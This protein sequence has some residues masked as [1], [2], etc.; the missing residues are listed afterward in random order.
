MDGLEFGYH[1]KYGFALFA[2]R[3]FQKGEILLSE[4]PLIVS[5]T[6]TSKRD[7]A[8][9]YT[10]DIDLDVFSTF[11]AFFDSSIEIQ[12]IILNNFYL[13]STPELMDTADVNRDT[14]KRVFLVF[15]F[16]SHA[17]GSDNSPA[18][19]AIGSKMN[20]SCEAN[21]FYQSIDN[22][23]E[24]EQWGAAVKAYDEQDFD[25]ALDTFEYLRGNMLIDYEQ[26]GLKFRLYSCEVL[27]NRGLCYLYLGQTDQGLGD[28]SFAVKEKQT[29]EH[30][31]I[32][33]AIEVQ[34]K[35]KNVKTKDYLGKAKLVAA[36]DPED[37]FTGFTG[38]QQ[39]KKAQMS[40]TS[41][42][43]TGKTDGAV[44]D[45]PRP[46]SPPPEKVVIRPK[47]LSTNPKSPPFPIRATRDPSSRRRQNESAENKS[48]VRSGASTPLL[49]TNGNSELDAPISR[50][51]SL[52]KPSPNRLQLQN[53]PQ[54]SN[55]IDGGRPSP[56]LP[57]V[58][59]RVNSARE[60]NRPPMQRSSSLRDP[61]GNSNLRDPLSRSNSLRA[62]SPRGGVRTPQRL[63]TVNRQQYLQQQMKNMTVT[64]GYNDYNQD[65]GQYDN[66]DYN[67][68]SLNE[69]RRTPSL[70]G[71]GVNTPLKGSSFRSPLGLQGGLA[72][73]P[74]PEDGDYDY[75]NIVDD[76]YIYGD[77]DEPQFEM[78][79]PPQ[80]NFQQSSESLKIVSKIRVKCYYK[81]KTPRAIMVSTDIAYE[82]LSKRIQEKFSL[83]NPLKMKYKDE[84]GTMVMMGDQEDLDMAI[85]IIPM[86]ATDVGKMEVW[87]FV[88]L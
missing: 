65:P 44:L 24:L 18:I 42:L 29:E 69:Q 64:D 54:R 9:V 32:D 47:S 87:L 70:R 19:F 88:I 71:R 6:L 14:F 79:S 72:T 51:V 33:E 86:S 2:T 39:Q 30:D 49:D 27:F 74:T 60:S 41:P 73:P 82:D 52:R 78:I 81:D 17:F 63:N 61:V 62:V 85:S 26:L 3:D 1:P 38:A 23:Y 15:T 66:E 11:K 76:G 20:H 55:T 40:T 68:I 80:Q 83:N 43:N 36:V 25:L 58:P 37:A 12:N 4:K 84:D 28:F 59:V 7:K 22:Q 77:E 10:Y 31:V 13:P 16:N 57:T 53:N 21:T 34:G 50:N 45:V 75:S 35:L 46:E 5:Q 8:F 67:Q 48:S 56:K